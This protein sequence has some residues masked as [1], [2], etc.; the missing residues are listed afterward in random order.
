MQLNKINI[1]PDYTHFSSGY[2]LSLDMNIPIYIGKNDSVRLLNEILEGL[3]YTQ[4]LNAYSS[5]GR[6]SAVPPVIMFKILVY[7]YMNRCFSSRDIERLCQRDIHFLWLLQGHKPPSHNSINRFRKDRLINGVV[8]NLF[9]Q[10]IELLFQLDEITFE[11][12]F[13]DGS[14]I[15]ANA[16]RYSFVWLRAIT[17]NEANLHLKIKSFIETYNSMYFTAHQFDE[18]NPLHE[19]NC[20]LIEL[21]EKVKS[22]SIQFVYGKG[23]RKTDLQRQIETLEDYIEKQMIYTSYQ[24]TIGNNRSSCSKTDSDATFM[25]MKE[26]HM[27]NGQLKPGYNI[28]LGVEAEYIVGIGVFSQANDLNTLI[29]FLTSLENRFERKFQNII[30]DAGYESEEN[31]A[32][33]KDNKQ[34]AFIKPVNYEQS[35][36]KKYKNQI[37][38][39]ENMIYDEESDSY[40]CASG[41]KLYPTDQKIRKTKTGY[42]REITIYECESCQ[43]CPLRLNCTKAK[44][45]NHKRVEV[46]K[47]MIPL[48]EESFTNITSEK[49]VL[50]RQNRSIQVEGAFG[51]LKQDY[52]FRRFLTR[53]EINVTVEFILLGF[54]YNLQKLH[55]KIQKGRCGQKLHPLKVA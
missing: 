13:V 9:D 34:K 29:P 40:T 33:L 8:E 21:K 31:Y 50:L 28:Q 43:G 38:K 25:R 52:G 20:C 27:K 32:F 19:L 42:E 10:F 12:L 2:Q 30:A 17:K 41:K 22:Q 49:G 15:E 4:L 23:R 7:A 47:R 45:G 55:N 53:G 37:G 46:S 18:D 5:K 48:R 35:K 36:T 14:K 6:N 51:V 26:D 24:E 54:A 44:E 1:Q 16:N 11:N 39:R 3:N